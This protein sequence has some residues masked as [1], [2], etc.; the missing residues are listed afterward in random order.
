MYSHYIRV[1]D[2]GVIIAGFSSASEDPQEDDILILEEGPR[3]FHLAF[4][5]LL[6]N[7]RGQFRFKWIDGERI[8]RSQEELDA[9]WSARPPA[10]PSDAERIAQLEAD[11]S[12]LALSLA[13]SQARLTATEQGQADLLLQLVQGGVL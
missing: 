11:N 13:E 2:A 1:D 8:E 4:P 10:P 9:E 6:T 12:L 3:H 5:D 7:E